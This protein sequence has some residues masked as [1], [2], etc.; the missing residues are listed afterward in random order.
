MVRIYAPTPKD[1][2][3]I[4]RHSR[5]EQLTKKFVR[6]EDICVLAPLAISLYCN[7]ILIIPATNEVIVHDPR[8]LEI[9]IKLA[10]AYEKDFDEEF[11][12]KKEY[13]TQ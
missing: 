7:S 2:E 3:R 8:K 13:L 12:V 1:I 6:T 4:Q 10:A 5:L 11:M 9:S